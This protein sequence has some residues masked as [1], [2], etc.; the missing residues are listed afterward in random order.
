MAISTRDGAI[1]ARLTFVLVFSAKLPTIKARNTLATH[2]L[3]YCCSIT[4]SSTLDHRTTWV[5]AYDSL[6]SLP[7]A[8]M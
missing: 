5:H 2:P 7:T 6:A 3:F 4:C 1:K 8:P